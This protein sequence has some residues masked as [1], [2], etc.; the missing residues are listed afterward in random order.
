MDDNNSE[1][2]ENNS[3]E[4][5]VLRRYFE[6]TW[7]KILEKVMAVITI[8]HED[9]AKQKIGPRKIRVGVFGPYPGINKEI[10]M[11]VARIVSELGFAAITGDGFYS[12]NNSSDFH[13]IKEIS[14]PEITELFDVPD[15]PQYHYYHILP[16]LVRKAI[17]L[18]NDEGGQTIELIGCFDARIPVLGFIVH[19]VITYGDSDCVYLLKR[20]DVSA[21]SVPDH[22]SCLGNARKRPKCPFYD[23]ISISWL[24]KQL[25]L[26]KRQHHL[27]A[28][29]NIQSFRSIINTFLSKGISK[30]YLLDNL[31]DS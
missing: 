7:P 31:V 17:F 13:D 23:S 5:E 2:E 29:K 18:M 19:N 24:S 30:E 9:R 21:C 14:P 26:R 10:I 27:V 28:V 3:S 15:I 6:K 12:P 1:F 16:R 11:Q 22:V 25:F 8:F 20:G 4:E